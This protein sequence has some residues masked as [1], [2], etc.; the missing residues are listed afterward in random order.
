[1]KTLKKGLVNLGETV[2]WLAKSSMIVGEEHLP[3]SIRE[4][5][6]QRS[7]NLSGGSSTGPDV[8]D[9]VPGLVTVIN[10]TKLDKKVVC[11]IYLTV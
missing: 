2:N 1:M 11:T 8:P 10:M 6:G 3:T 7:R 4:L 9:C 5:T